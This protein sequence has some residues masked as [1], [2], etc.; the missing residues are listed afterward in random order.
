[1]GT[2]N[3]GEAN[4]SSLVGS[5]Q[6]PSR[7]QG[8]LN[9]AD[10]PLGTS[11]RG[12]VEVPYWVSVIWGGGTP[13]WYQIGNEGYCDGNLWEQVWS[14]YRCHRG[15]LFLG[16]TRWW[17]EMPNREAWWSGCRLQLA[18]DPNECG[19]APCSRGHWC[20]IPPLRGEFWLIRGPARTP[21]RHLREDVRSRGDTKGDREE[22]GRWRCIPICSRNSSS[23]FSAWRRN[24][25][26]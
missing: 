19:R 16:Q 15:S 20:L 6:S 1:M 4:S 3:V 17:P 21:R 18:L 11:E 5:I 2:L 26:T 23:M 8:C 24:F 10:W 22:E 25:S 7:G 13:I 9:W 14:I 12:A